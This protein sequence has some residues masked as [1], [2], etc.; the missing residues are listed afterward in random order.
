MKCEH[1]GI[2][3]TSD[4]KLRKYCSVKCRR[5]AER[6]RK[7]NSTENR[8]TCLICGKSF[9]RRIGIERYCSAECRDEMHRRWQRENRKPVI[10]QCAACG[11][12]FTPRNNKQ[13]YCSPDCY[14]ATHKKQAYDY[15]ILQRQTSA[16]NRAQAVVDKQV[17]RP[18]KTLDDWCREAAACG[19]DYGNYRALVAQGLTFEQIKARWQHIPLGG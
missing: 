16:Q 11:K 3:F 13:K 8:T 18:T 7:Q 2:E 12:D 9:V 15:K 14:N 5:A 6:D 19:L 17:K 10:K 4:N 1:C